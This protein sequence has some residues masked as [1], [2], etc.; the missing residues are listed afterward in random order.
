MEIHNFAKRLNVSSR[1]PR[2]PKLSELKWNYMNYSVRIK[3]N[4][5]LC[6][7]M[8]CA[9]VSEKVSFY[10]KNIAFIREH[11]QIFICIKWFRFA[12]TVK[13]RNCLEENEIDIGQPALSRVK[14]NAQRRIHNLVCALEGLKLFNY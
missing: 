9:W 3:F 1:N 11:A 12:H 6:L 2:K 14:N 13:T 8:R 10:Y 5:V 7:Y 4:Y